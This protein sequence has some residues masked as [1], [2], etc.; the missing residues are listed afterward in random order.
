MVL[1]LDADSLAEVKKILAFYAPTLKAWAFG[2]RAT[3]TAKRFSDLDLALEGEGRVDYQTISKLKHA[4]A[5]SDLPIKVD[6][7]DWNAL[8]PEFRT[9]IDKQRVL[10]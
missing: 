1:Q 7:V 6:I 9:V 5:E 8:D 3:G 10:L 2:S 4:F